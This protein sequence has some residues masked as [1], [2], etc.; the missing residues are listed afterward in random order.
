LKTRTNK[1]KWTKN[2]KNHK[3]VFTERSSNQEN[4]SG[5]HL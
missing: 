2:R 4:G 5:P 3:I 1:M